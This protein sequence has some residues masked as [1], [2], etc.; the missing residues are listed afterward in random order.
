MIAHAALIERSPKQRA[1]WSERV[2]RSGV[3]TL[4]AHLAPVHAGGQTVSAAPGVPRHGVFTGYDAAPAAILVVE[5]D[6]VIG[7]ALVEQLAADGFRVE[8][9]RTAEHAR[10]LAAERVPKL[11]VIGDLDSARDGLELLGEIREANRERAPWIHELPVIVVSSRAHELDM[12][13]A[14]EAGADDFLARP[15]RYLELR[16]RLRAILRRSESIPGEE[17]CL[18]VGP[19]AIDLQAHMATLHGQHL[20]L[21]RLEYELLVALASVPDRVFGKQEL[22][23]L[24]WGYRSCAATRT[25][26]SHASRLRRKLVEADAHPPERW[27]INV[28]GV[29][30]RLV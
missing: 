29:G 5:A 15:A 19:L 3:G 23:S 18:Q 28:W 16:A 13:R 30:Y 14:F 11:A 9:A 12:L 7:N 2:A 1:A 8:L 4:D 27:V 10:A 17:R 22:L 26:D 24:V 20:D 21:R 25:V 6:A